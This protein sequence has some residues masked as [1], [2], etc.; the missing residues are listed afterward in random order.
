MITIQLDRKI[1]QTFK[2]TVVIYDDIEML[3][4]NQKLSALIKFYNKY[5][6]IV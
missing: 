2:E 3:T 5:K 1:I 6:D 4:Y